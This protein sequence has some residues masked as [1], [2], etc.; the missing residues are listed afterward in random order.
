MGD[1]SAHAKYRREGEAGFGINLS[2]RQPIP[3]SHEW[4]DVDLRVEIRVV[5]RCANVAHGCKG[6]GSI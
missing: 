4:V 2:F 6:E 5:V 1:P 3:H